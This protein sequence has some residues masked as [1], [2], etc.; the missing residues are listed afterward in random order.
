MKKLG[1]PIVERAREFQTRDPTFNELGQAIVRYEKVLAE[2][3]AGVSTC[4]LLYILW[5]LSL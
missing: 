2:Y 1:D 5:N 3:E 4:T